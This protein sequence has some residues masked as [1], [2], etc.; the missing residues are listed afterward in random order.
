[1]RVY[2]GNLQLRDIIEKESLKEIETFLNS[3]GFTHTSDTASVGSKEGNYHIY[4][5]PRQIHICGDIKAKEF[6]D[7]IM[8][9]DLSK[10]FVGSVAVNVVEPD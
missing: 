3:N 8:D 9:N 7:F 10:V 4:S 2:F 6:V 1:M 5:E